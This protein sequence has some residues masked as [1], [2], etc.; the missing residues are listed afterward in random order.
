MIIKKADLVAVAVK[1]DQYPKD[2][3]KEIAFV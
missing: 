2:D 3:K 1:K